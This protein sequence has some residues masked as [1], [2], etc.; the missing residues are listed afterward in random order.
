MSLIVEIKEKQLTARKSG[1]KSASLLTTLLS[2]AT[3]IGKNAGNRETTDQEV[4]AVVKKFIKNIDETI[5]ALK[6]RN[7]DATSFLEEKSVLESFLPK[8][9]STQ[10]LK[11]IASGRTGM[12]D[13]MKY[14]KEN[15]NGQYDGKLASAVA[16]EVF[17]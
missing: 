13:F 14:L 9:L 11:D 4:I 12:P 2:E 1:S 5:E 7:Q 17:Q 3:V 10:E 6:S 15:F 16:K 8:Q